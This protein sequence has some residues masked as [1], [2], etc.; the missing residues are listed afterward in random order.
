MTVDVLKYRSNGIFSGRLSQLFFI[1]S[2]AVPESFIPIDIVRL[3]FKTQQQ[4]VRINLEKLVILTY[5]I[6]TPLIKKGITIMYTNNEEFEKM[7]E[8][9]DIDK[10]PPADDTERQYYFIKKAREYVKEES[11]K[12]G[13]PLLFAT[14]TFGCPTV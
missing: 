7:L 10:E 13:R 12:L 3:L 2:T 14:V 5:N 11:K 4:L 1:I 9:I 6:V 8:T